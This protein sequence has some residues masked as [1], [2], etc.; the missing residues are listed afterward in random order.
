MSLKSLKAFKSY[1]WDTALI[2]CEKGLSL[3]F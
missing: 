3:S 1:S 2:L